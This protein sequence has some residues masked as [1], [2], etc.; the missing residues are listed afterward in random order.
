MRRTTTGG[1]IRARPYRA[2]PALPWAIASAV[3]HVLD[4][5]VF[6]QL[7]GEPVMAFAG[8][9]RSNLHRDG[10]GPPVHAPDD[11]SGSPAADH[12]PQAVSFAV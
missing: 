10:V 3:R 2:P 5:T 11:P 4:A 7:L 1:V 12:E 6:A 9:F 8:R